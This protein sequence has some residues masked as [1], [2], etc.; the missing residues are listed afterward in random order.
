VPHAD[1]PREDARANDQAFVLVGSET[2]AQEQQRLGGPGAQAPGDG[3]DWPAEAQQEGPATNDARRTVT[4]TAALRDDNDAT[5]TASTGAIPEVPGSWILRVRAPARSLDA[6]ACVPPPVLQMRVSADTNPQA[7]SDG[8]RHALQLER[9]AD[10]SIPG[11]F[12]EG[13]GVYY[14]LSD[15]LARSRHPVN[16]PRIFS[17]HAPP[18]P[19]RPDD[20][21]RKQRAQRFLLESIEQMCEWMQ[22]RPGATMVALVVVAVG[23]SAARSTVHPLQWFLTLSPT[24]EGWGYARQMLQSAFHETHDRAIVSP[25]R[26]MYRNGPWIIGGWEGDR[27]ERVCARITY[28]GDEAFWSRNL[29]ECERIYAAKE[30]A[31]LRL[32]RPLANAIVLVMIFLITRRALRR[33]IPRGLSPAERDAVE[34]YRAIHVLVRQLKKNA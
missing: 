8:I 1:A 20:S 18:L 17:L 29:V 4:S 30:A 16:Q 2:G 15:V 25:L 33:P 9:A 31:W 32:T 10:S 27:L 24:R 28:H 12:D 23:I 13:T 21:K 19:P 26:D 7:L 34:T 14:F 5:Q 11:L 22:A 6:S 3:R